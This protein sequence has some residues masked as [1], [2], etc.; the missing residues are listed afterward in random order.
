MFLG[1]RDLSK[2]P[3]FPAKVILYETARRKWKEL[4]SALMFLL[5]QPYQVLEVRRVRKYAARGSCYE[6]DNRKNGACLN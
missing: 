6:W 4:C 3:Q 5:D 2:E 1:L